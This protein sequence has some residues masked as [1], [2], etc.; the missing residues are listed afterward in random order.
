MSITQPQGDNV[1]YGIIF[2]LPDSSIKELV[3]I[4]LCNV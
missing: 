4:S 2:L 1:S 3:S